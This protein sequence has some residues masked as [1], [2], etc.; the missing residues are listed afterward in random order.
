MY[1]DEERYQMQNEEMQEVL[2]GNDTMSIK[3]HHQQMDEIESRL[4]DVS[5][6]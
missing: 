1:F 2:L 5:F 6:Y 3:L 4:R